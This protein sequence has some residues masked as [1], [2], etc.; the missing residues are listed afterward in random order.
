MI[1]NRSARTDGNP[2]AMGL[3]RGLS[4][5]DPIR[6][7]VSVLRPVWSGSLD[8]RLPDL[9]LRALGQF[10]EFA[11]VPAGLEERFEVCQAQGH[12]PQSNVIVCEAS[13]VNQVLVVPLVVGPLSPAGIR[14]GRG[15]RSCH[16]VINQGLTASAGDL[17]RSS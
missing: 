4:D 14:E 1:R 9:V 7:R 15:G 10:R 17:C 13:I 12:L 5:H 16:G 6:E 3:L 11:H 2:I 8:R